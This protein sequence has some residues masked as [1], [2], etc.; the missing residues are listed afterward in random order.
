MLT[1]ARDYR[2][3]NQTELAEQSETTQGFI[4]QVEQ[5]QKEASEHTIA[6]WAAVLR[7]PESFFFQ[8]DRYTGFGLSLVFHRKRSGT[9]VA[10]MRRLQAEVNLRR[11]HITRL[12]NAV[13]IE[14]A[15][16][17]ILMDIDDYHGDSERVAAF[18]R[19]SWKLPIGPIRNLVEVIEAAGGIVFK[20]PF[21][22]SDVDAMSQWPV[23]S[24]PLFFLN[25]EAPNDRIRFS[26][27]HEI[28]HVVMHRNATGDIESEADRFAGELLMPAS[29]IAPHLD[30]MSLKLALRL[31][32]Y[33]RVAMQALIRRARDLGRI[34]DPH[35]S[36]LFRQLSALGMRKNEPS[37]ISPE[38][39][40]LVNRIISEYQRV[41]RCTQSDVAIALCI[42][43]EEFQSLYGPR[44]G[45]RV[46]N[47]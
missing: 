46:A 32:P 42:S 34:P 4:S 44:Q 3:L 38:H 45:L 30:N 29:E 23:D 21:V 14:T 9:Q 19:A 12:L 47:E 10:H 37:P 43:E 36:R 1:L 22:T 41:N 13:E 16:E 35:Y 27:A 17:F 2:G 39:P 25:S 20:F 5:R 7:V 40:T 26:L 8:R 31:K 28:G 24:P 6:R 11:I 15:N 33:W 18:V